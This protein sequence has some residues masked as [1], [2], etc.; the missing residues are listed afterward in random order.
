MEEV[1]GSGV[2]ELRLGSWSRVTSVVCRRDCRGW[3]ERVQEGGREGGRMEERKEE[4]RDGRMEER[5]EGG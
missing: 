3:G 4:G 1:E 5:K 2:V